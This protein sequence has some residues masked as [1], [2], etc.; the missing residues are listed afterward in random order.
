MVIHWYLASKNNNELDFIIWQC[1]IKNMELR[2]AR[3]D[4]LL[5]QIIQI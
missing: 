5:K 4:T 1:E 3:F 2:K